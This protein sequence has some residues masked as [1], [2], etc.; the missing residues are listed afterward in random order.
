MK[1]ILLLLSF[2]ILKTYVLFCQTTFNPIVQSQNNK[3]TIEQIELTKDETIVTIKVPTSRIS[4]AYVSFSSNTVLV[5]SDSLDIYE[6]REISLRHDDFKPSDVWEIPLYAKYYEILDA[7]KKSLSDDGW[8]IRNLGS[9]ELDVQYDINTY[10]VDFYYFDLHFDR[11]P[12]NCENVYIRELV[13]GGFEWVGI[14]LN[15]PYPH[16]PNLGYNENEI[17]S[18]I[19]RQN[20]GIVGIYEGFSENKYKLACIIDSKVYK[21]MYMGSEKNLEQWKF[22]DVKATLTPSATPGLFKATWY[23]ENKSSNNNCYIMFEDGIMKCAI[24]GSESGY[25]KMYPYFNS[26]I[27]AQKQEWTGTGFALNNGYVVTNYHVVE[28]AKSIYIQGLNGD[29]SKKYKSTIIASDKTNDLAILKVSDNYS[30]NYSSLPYS[31]KS[32]TC[33]VGEEVFVLGYPLVSSMGAEIKLTTGVI[34]SKSGYE[35]DISLYQVSTP[36]QPGNSGAPLFDHN[37]NIIGVINAKHKD[38]ENVGYAIKSSYLKNLI[39]SF[40]PTS[41]I[42]TRN[43]IYNLPLTQKVKSLKNSI[44]LISC[45][46]IE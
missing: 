27:N 39:E 15:N 42:P 17:T 3:C 10:D 20:D 19:D 30:L 7:Y 12:Y 37:G 33:E 34:S 41:A 46:N 5:P 31:I 21:L 35:G 28:N 16:V 38:A 25:L 43:S 13:K 11:L 24:N 23:M 6:A 9:N 29:F 14:Q 26:N 4:G 18:L 1:K 45:S 44:F 8:L 2:I 22:G 32:S 40:L 36:I